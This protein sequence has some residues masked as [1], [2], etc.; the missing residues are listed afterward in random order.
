MRCGVMRTIVHLSDIH[1]GQIARSVIEPLV[2]TVGALQPDLVVVSGDLTQQA[3]RREFRAAKEFLLSL[4]RPQIVVPGNHDIP[5]W[6]PIVRFTAPLSRF[7]HYIT[8]DLYPFYEDDEIA[9]IGIN[10][11]RSRATKYGHINPTQVR[12]MRERLTQVSSNKI[13]IVVTHH[14]FDLP[15]G[16]RNGRQ[17][18]RKS[19]RAMAVLAECGVDLFLA[20]H[21]HRAFVGHTAERYNIENFGAVI[22]Q[23][24]TIAEHHTPQQT[25]FNVIECD[26]DIIHVTHFEWDTKHNG[27]QAGEKQQFIDSPSGWRR[28]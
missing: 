26:G 3:R 15:E 22:V 21:L 14:P 16:Y 19:R 13:K 11:A 1:F 20:G 28:D 12:V 2:G 24:G 18:V 17:I 6:N 4:P 23:A 10:T 7:K 27:F 8:R 25:G 9:V 5:I